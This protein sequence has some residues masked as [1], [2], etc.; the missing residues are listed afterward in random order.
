VTDELYDRLEAY[1]QHVTTDVFYPEWDGDQIVIVREFAADSPLRAG[2]AGDFDVHPA[3]V[4]LA[5]LRGFDAVLDAL[6]RAS[7]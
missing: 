6:P 3:A 4:E 7:A 5:L 1:G 2:E